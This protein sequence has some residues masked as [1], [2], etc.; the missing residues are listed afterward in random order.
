M[1]DQS[2]QRGFSAVEAVVAVVIVLAVVAAGWFVF[3]R[4]QGDEPETTTT[5]TPPAP[6]VNETGD[7][8][9]ATKALDDTN[10]DVSSQDASELDQELQDF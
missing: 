8:D 2:K 3:D 6:D 10:L 4:M 9:S 7:L 5:T 1:S